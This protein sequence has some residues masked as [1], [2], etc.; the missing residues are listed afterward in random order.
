MRGIAFTGLV[1]LALAGT[2][3]AACPQYM[4][5]RIAANDGTYLGTIAAPQEKE[6]IFNAYGPY[7]SK[8]SKTSIFNEY[9]IYGS[10][11]SPQSAF[12]PYATK[13]PVIQ[14]DGKPV[15]TLTANKALEGAISVNKL[16]S[17]C[18]G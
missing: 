17:I 13:P 10:P 18:R 6:S 4:G 5:A 1:F 12:N 14:K 9:G 16:I 8:F 15:G 11:S 2:A 7:G 3:G